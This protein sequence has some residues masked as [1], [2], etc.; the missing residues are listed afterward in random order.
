MEEEAVALGID[1]HLDELDEIL[2]RDLNSN[3]MT[4]LEELSV[5]ERYAIA[6]FEN[7]TPLVGA[8]KALDNPQAW[9]QRVE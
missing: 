6:Y 4:T 5:L 1:R 9:I 8:R 3:E 7:D 2:R